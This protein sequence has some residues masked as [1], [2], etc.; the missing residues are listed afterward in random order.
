MSVFVAGATAIGAGTFGAVADDRKRT[1][2][3]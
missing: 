2:A 3:V 1:P